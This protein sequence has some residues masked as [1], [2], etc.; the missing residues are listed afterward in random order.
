MVMVIQSEISLFSGVSE[1]HVDPRHGAEAKIFEAS[2]SHKKVRRSLG[3]N[4][5][6]M[7]LAWKQSM[8]RHESL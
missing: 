1:A 6:I 5:I 3:L 2:G 7:T 8:A 4:N